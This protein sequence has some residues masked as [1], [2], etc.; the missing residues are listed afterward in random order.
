M[1]SI[2]YHSHPLD[3]TATTSHT[4]FPSPTPTTHL[5]TP[6]PP[7]HHTFISKTK[8]IHPQS[9]HTQT[10]ESPNKLPDPLTIPGQHGKRI[11]YA[12]NGIK[13]SL[14]LVSFSMCF[15]S[16]SF[17]CLLYFSIRFYFSFSIPL[18]VFLLYFIYTFISHFLF[19]HLFTLFFHA[20]FYFL[21]IFFIILFLQLLR[22]L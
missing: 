20:Y 7:F 8:V 6:L 22:S 2:Y 11:Q 17:I 12:G 18:F 5:L 4:K 21:F 10:A 9:T 19:P 3:L 15:I 14:V 13:Y 16:Y 1:G